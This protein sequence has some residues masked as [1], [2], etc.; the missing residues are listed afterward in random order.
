[1]FS[2]L[3]RLSVLASGLFVGLFVHIAAYANDNQGW[4]A[5]AL[6]GPVSEKSRWLAWFDGHARFADD[7]S[8][9]GVSII[10]PGFGRRINA[11]LNLWGGYA[12]VTIHLDGP[13]IEEDRAW[14][15]A[16]FPFSNLG[17][18]PLNFP[19]AP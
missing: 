12:R 4:S 7:A 14:Q 10:R 9:L 6:S 17:R 18:W 13:D 8:D 5:I 19:L 11:N 16:T 3:T 15:Q 1:M 2:R